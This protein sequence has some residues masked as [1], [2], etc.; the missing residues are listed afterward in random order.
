MELYLKV[1]FDE[2]EWSDYLHTHSDLILEDSGLLDGVKSG[3][4][5]EVF[6]LEKFEDVVKE[7][8]TTWKFHR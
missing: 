5:V 8:F 4:S 3:V 1:T 7:P 6:D 2:T